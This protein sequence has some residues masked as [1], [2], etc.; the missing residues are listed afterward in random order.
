M[1]KIYAEKL[2]NVLN[3][4]IASGR[5]SEVL[6][7]LTAAELEFIAHD[8]QLWARD[9]Q[10]APLLIGASDSRSASRPEAPVT[11]SSALAVAPVQ[12]VIPGEPACPL[13]SRPTRNTHTR[14]AAGSPQGSR[15]SQTKNGSG[16]RE[17]LK[18]SGT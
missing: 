17:A 15:R 10:L 4:S 9:D 6:N 12:L 16:A 18:R 13:S 7:E 1:R 2:R 8:W 11:H 14:S 3:A 5:L